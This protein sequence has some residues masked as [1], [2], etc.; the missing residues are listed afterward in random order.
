MTRTFSFLFLF[1]FLASCGKGGSGSSS[2]MA[3]LSDAQLESSSVAPV[4]AQTFEINADM[5]GF[6]REQEDKLLDAFDRIKRVVGSDEFKRRVLGH[7][8]KGK[9]QFVDNGGYSNAQVYK[10]ILEGAE[11]LTP[12]K[13]NAMDLVLETYTESNI[14]IG[15]TMPSIRTIYMNT[16]Y[17][18]RS[19]FQP[20]HVAMNLTHEWLHKLGFKHAQN[21]SSSRPHS[22]PYAVGYIMRDLA[23]KL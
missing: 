16:K 17:L 6:D 21:N 3:E 19:G 15:Y 2:G 9:K 23:A 11:K 8:Y 12:K 14:V 22:V 20:N 18:N 10:A 5:S 7:T 1:L 4:Q 13:N